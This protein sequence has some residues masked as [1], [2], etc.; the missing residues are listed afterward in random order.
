MY[1]L[2]LLILLLPE[3]SSLKVVSTSFGKLRGITEWSDETNLKHIFKKNKCPV[4]VYYHG[5]AFNLDSATMFPDKFILDRYVANDIVFA[6]PAF[7]L[8][9]FGQLYFGP[10]NVLTENLLMFDAVKALDFVHH[11]IE[12][13]GG[14]TKRVTVMG[15][16]SGGTLVDAL[17]FSNLIDPDIKMFQQLIVLSAPGMFGFYE[18]VVENSF[19]FAEKLGV[20]TGRY[21]K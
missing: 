9:V 12:N 7:R 6:I 5:G 11:E 4:I 19:T 13:F 17:G 2:F 10:S 14:D 8:G 21:L 1:L 16:S 15:H 20:R 3:I 18:M